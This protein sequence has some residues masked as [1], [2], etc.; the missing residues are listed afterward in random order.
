MLKFCYKLKWKTIESLNNFNLVF[1]YDENI[2]KIS[3]IRDILK[4]A[5]GI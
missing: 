2:K 4:V 5:V 1:K 3:E